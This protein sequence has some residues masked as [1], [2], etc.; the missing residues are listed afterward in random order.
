[1][2]TTTCIKYTGEVTE[3]QV[4]EV[5]VPSTEVYSEAVKDRIKLKAAK[6]YL[7]Q[8]AL[9]TELNTHIYHEIYFFQR[10]FWD[11]SDAT[12]IIF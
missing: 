5:I 9:D 7:L 11:Q 1:M 2:H 10:V 4:G 12:S 8:D 6:K 3:V